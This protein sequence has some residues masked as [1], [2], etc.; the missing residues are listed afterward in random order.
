MKFWFNIII[1]FGIVFFVSCNYENIKV[2]QDILKDNLINSYIEKGKDKSVPEEERRENL[3]KAYNMTNNLS[4]SRAKLDKFQEI[5]LG[6]FYL[7]DLKIYRRLNEKALELSKFLNDSL[8]IANT[9]TNLGIYYRVNKLDSAYKSF[10]EAE[11]IY[12]S[13]DEKKQRNPSEYAYDYGRLLVDLALLSKKVKDYNESEDLTIKAIEK[14]ELSGDLK[15]IPLCYTNLGSVAKY[16]ERYEDAVIYNQ[17]AI[18]YAKNTDKEVLYAVLGNNNIGT[19]FKSQ[20]KYDEA[21]Q[22]YQKGLSFEDFLK[23]NPRRYA[24]LLD[25]LA[26]ANFL[27]ET[28]KFDPNPFFVALRIRDSINDSYGIATNVLH[29]SEYYKSID[30]DSLSRKFAEKAK[31]VATEI[32]SNNELLQSYQLLSEVS[33]PE[34]G[35]QYAQKYIALNDSLIKEERAF[36]DK[37]ARIRFETDQ[38]EEKIVEI[39][40]KNQFLVIITLGLTLLSL[41]AYIIFR[42]RQRNKELE[43]AKKQQETN[44]EIYRLLLTQQAKLEEGRKME[45]QRMS[46]E[47]HD[48]V[49]GRL[50]GVRLSLDGIN[51]RANDGFTDSRNKYIEE[52]KSIEKEIRLISHDLGSDTLS[53]DIAYVDVVE[54]LIHDLC[55]VNEIQFDF[56]SNEDINWEVIDDQKKVNLFRIIQESLQNIFKHAKAD[57]VKISFDYMDGEIKLVIEDNGVGFNKE[58]VKRGIGLKN[59]TSRVKQMNGN[60]DFESALGEGAKVFVGIP[61]SDL[62]I[63]KKKKPEFSIAPG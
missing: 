22:Y 14:F 24:M 2:E 12:K 44:E 58:R 29:L 39:S 27:A 37:F 23:K 51:Q 57:H 28:G 9:Y 54:S 32:D 30:Q 36:R 21:I 4:D 13:L 52:L 53:K 48:G 50:F 63:A 40:R 17:K 45:Q 25:N 31:N 38:K 49:L 19:V 7:S 1:L 33:S 16:L 8:E 60:V 10:Y 5:S 47:L 26:Y 43:F 41:L 42:Q 18:E 56:D 34:E 11:K 46:E 61:V 62:V 15:Y 59:I 35:L 3:S 6:Y 55:S 20:K